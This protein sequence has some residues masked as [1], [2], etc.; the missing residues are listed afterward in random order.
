MRGLSSPVQLPGTL[1]QVLLH[2]PHRTLTDLR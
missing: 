2:P 1:P